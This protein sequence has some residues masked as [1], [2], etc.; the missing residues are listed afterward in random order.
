MGVIW[1]NIISK[2]E[3]TVSNKVKISGLWYSKKV[4]LVSFISQTIVCSPKDLI[5]QTHWIYCK[6]LSMILITI[7]TINVEWIKMKAVLKVTEG[8]ILPME[9][10]SGNVKHLLSASKF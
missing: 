10:G 1:T 9:I 8:W 7:D 2:E 3:G 4:I 6:K 5:Y